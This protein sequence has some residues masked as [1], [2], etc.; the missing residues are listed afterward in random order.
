VSLQ[1]GLVDRRVSRPNSVN[2]HQSLTDLAYQHLRESILGG[3]LDSGAP[4]RQDD[5]ADILGI[6][7]IPVREALRRLEVEGLVILQPHRG[8][9]VAPLSIEEINDVFETLLLLEEQAGYIAAM[10]RTE[11]D[12][13]EIAACL[14]KLD[15]IIEVQPFDA[16]E[17][18]RYNSK[19]HERLL[20]AC[21]RPHLCRMLRLLHDS[22]ER[23]T[24][25]GATLVV[26]LEKSHREHHA[27]MD[28]FRRGDAKA[29]S[30]LCRVHR[31]NTHHRLLDQLKLAR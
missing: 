1:R 30:K 28:A 4:I 26:D 31:E 29:V 17:F 11:E 10:R 9:F 3:R 21:R 15:R 2:G 18:A 13:S 23:Y 14:D 7:R 20:F 8:Y 22:V 5:V 12:V 19:F 6:S 27:I 24:R 25:M 16:A